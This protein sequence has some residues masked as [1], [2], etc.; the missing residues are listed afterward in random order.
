MKMKSLLLYSILLIGMGL[1]LEGCLNDTEDPNAAHNAE[2]KVIDDY[3]TSHN[4]QDVL[5]D[6]QYGFRLLI[7][8]AGSGAPPHQGDIVQGTY[9]AKILGADG[10]LTDFDF[11]Q[12]NSKL[13]DITPGALSYLASYTMKGS[14]ATVF[15][16]SRHAFGESGNAT[17][18][19]PANAIV[20]Y[21]LALTDVVHTASWKDRFGI[22]TTLISDY[23]NDPMAP[24]EG[25][26]KHPSGFWYKVNVQGSGGLTPRSYS[27]VTFDYELRRL[28]GSGPGNIIQS[29]TLEKQSTWGLIDGLKI[30]IPLLQEG[31]DVTF[32][33]PSGYGYGDQERDNI[34][35]NSLLM[36]KIKL[37]TVDVY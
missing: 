35:K 5:F 11:G 22:D 18:Q 36:F 29:G 12:V 31:M 16:P 26:I 28:L 9:S 30:G 19:V 2:V 10:T 33:F 21:T 20:V 34:P 32:Y 6:Y 27:F 8:S 1:G 4:V 17:L 14:T 7:Q 15:S 24:V 37:K 25:A 3:I 23:I 13:E